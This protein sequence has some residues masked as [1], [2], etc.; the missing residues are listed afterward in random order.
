[1][2][3][4]SFLVVVLV[5]T[6]VVAPLMGCASAQDKAASAQRQSS[7]A[8]LKIKQE[9]LRMIDEYRKCVSDAGDDMMKADSCDRILKAIEALK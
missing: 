5:S 3:N 4:S 6:L 2:N 1:M 8:D 9:R 7:Q